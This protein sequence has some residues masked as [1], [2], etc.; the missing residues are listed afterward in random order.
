AVGTKLFATDSREY[1]IAGVMND[2]NYASLRDEVKPFMILYDPKGEDINQ[3]IVH[4]RSTDYARMLGEMSALW[5]K[6]VPG[7]PFDY[8]FLDD[9][10]QHQYQSEITMS[11]I[12]NAFTGMAMVIS[13]LGLFGLA[14]FSAEKRSKEIGI[15]KV[16]GASNT[17]IFQLLS[18]DFIRLVAIAFVIATP[19]SWWAMHRWLQGFAY[20]VDLQW[21]MFVF[22]GI[23]AMV[24]ALFTVSFQSIKAAVANPV[25]GLRSE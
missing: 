19:V 14:A 2:I 13:C 20:K 11:H 25:K 15:R 6:D 22:A 17:G 3:L 16:L 21:W 1:R 24:I 8:S 4:T 7:T 18:G 9:K 23:A 5:H 12:I 10:V